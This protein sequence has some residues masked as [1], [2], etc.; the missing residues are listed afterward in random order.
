MAAKTK[1]LAA[2]GFLIL[3]SIAMTEAASAADACSLLTTAQV[4]AALGSA[5]KDGKAIGQ[6]LCM[7]DAAAPAKSGA[8][9]RVSLTVSNAQAF[10]FAKMPVQSANITK[11]PLSGV[12]DEAVYGTTAGQMASVNVKKG[13]TYFA[14]SVGGVPVDKTQALVTQLAKE[15]LGKL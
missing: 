13:S 6:K 1:I 9:P 8:T 4:S 2:T 11:T 14:I 15:A 10:A 5:V 3:A 12:G 7:W